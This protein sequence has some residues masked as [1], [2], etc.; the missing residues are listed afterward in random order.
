[1]KRSAALPRRDGRGRSSPWSRTASPRRT[2]RSGVRGPDDRSGWD[3]ESTLDADPANPHHRVT[4]CIP[5]LDCDRRGV[6]RGRW[7]DV[8]RGGP[9]DD[10]V[11]PWRQSALRLQRLRSAPRLR[12]ARRGAPAGDG[13]ARRNATTK[14]S[15]VG[16][17]TR[18]AVIIDRSPDGGL[19]W[20][21]PREL[22]AVTAPPY[23]ETTGSLAADPT[24][25]GHV[26]R[27]DR[28]SDGRGRGRNRHAVCRDRRRVARPGRRW[29][30][31]RTSSEHG[32]MNAARAKRARFPTVEGLWAGLTGS[33]RGPP[34][35][36]GPREG[37]IAFLTVQYRRRE[38]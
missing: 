17:A 33:P 32:D 15:V 2:A 37:L 23:V 1:M 8:G 28:Q 16:A 6:V 13:P 7:D 34:C 27:D 14:P 30:R 11:H 35:S 31:Q 19:T 3:T 12:P 36:P 24:C 4:A 9:T 5:Q 26:L 38:L 20:S 29:R 21:S 22:E 25:S 18:S 10:R